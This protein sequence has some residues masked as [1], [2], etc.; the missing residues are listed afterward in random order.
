METFVIT[1]SYKKPGPDQY[2][3]SPKEKMEMC[4]KCEHFIK[5]T[6]QCK[7]C[8]CFMPAKVHMHWLGCPVG[9]WEGIF[10]ESEEGPVPSDDVYVIDPERGPIPKEQANWRDELD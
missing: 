2:L 3:P 5:L 9:K 1:M 10:L 4:S 7:K 8:G 6:R